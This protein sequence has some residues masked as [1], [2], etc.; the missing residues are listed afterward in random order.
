MKNKI[1]NSIAAIYDQSEDC[2]LEPDFFAA[3]D[4]DLKMLSD[5]FNSTKEQALLIAMIFAKSF[6]ERAVSLNDLVTHFSCNPIRLLHYQDD[7]KFLTD[8]KIITRRVVSKMGRLGVNEYYFIN[9]NITEAILQNKPLPS[10]DL[11]TNVDIYE[12]LE[13]IYNIGLKRAEDEIS[14]AELKCLTRQIINQNKHFDLISKLDRFQFQILNSYL[15]LYLIWKTISGNETTDLSMALNGIYDVPAQKVSCLQELITGIN[16]L[17][18][19]DLIEIVENLFL[20]DSEMKLTSNALALLEECGI[21]VYVKKKNR[22]NII[23]P[24]DI[25]PKKLH[26]NDGEMNQLDTL[27][28][29]L[30]APYL[31]DVRKRLADKQLPTGVTVMLYGA[32]GTGKT[33]TVLQAAKLSGRHIMKVDL[34]NQKTMW[35]GES[36]KKVK[37]IFTDYREFS[38]ECEL[39]PILLFNEA[40]GILSKRREE[41]NG[42]VAQTENTIQNIL[43]EQL[44][45]FDGILIATTNLIGNLDN[46]FERRF[47]FKIEYTKPDHATKAKIWNSKLPLLEME[48]CKKLATTFGFSGGQIENIARKVEIQE[49]IDGIPPCFEAIT[50]FCKAE[51]IGKSVERIGFKKG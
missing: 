9:D 45:T 3:A 40:E 12:F 22:D 27:R 25:Q 16:E 36:E 48:A 43:L 26:F 29:L 20:N 4:S 41:M 50:A 6:N 5:Y 8:K 47:L 32:P 35:Y 34:S 10:V 28:K 7:L 15:L 21:K 19:N 14:T 33:E 31:T 51:L 39:T 37:R 11:K 38:K 30:M 49:I 46:A 44:E 17:V 1:L 13:E 42:N 24:E 23:K 2:K 18:K